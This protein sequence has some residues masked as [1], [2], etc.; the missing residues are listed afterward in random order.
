MAVEFRSFRVTL[1]SGDRYWT[2]IDQSYRPVVE[3][4]DFLLACRLGRDR[5]EGTTQAYATA[6]GLFL[7]WCKDS[8]TDWTESAPHLSRFVF[9]LQ[10]YDPQRR[11]SPGDETPIRG[12]RRVNAILAAVREFIRHAVSVG[13]VPNTILNAL[14][15]VVRDWD[16]PTE[17]RGERD[18]AYRERPRHRLSVP[19][20]PVD[21][22]TGEEILALLR[23]C[24]NSRDRFIVIALGRMGPRRGELTGARREDVH[25]VPDGMMLGCGVKGPHL[26]VVRRMN[27]NGAVAKSRRPRA[28]PADWLVVQAYDQYCM[29]RD[30]CPEAAGCDFL[31]VNLYQRPLGRPMRPQALNELL[32]RLSRRAGLGRVVHPHQLRHSFAN[33]VSESGATLDE[34]KDLLGHAAITSSE[35][36]LH[37]A[38]DRLREAVD[39]VDLPRLPRGDR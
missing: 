26:H 28:I 6:I 36:Y 19:D 12:P 39:R 33:A 18:V 8:G 4:D 3:V 9:W 16:L 5:A 11:R 10:H 37:P 27:P 7:Q 20:E 22:A 38:P 29:A 24:R 30:A 17:V 23:A 32:E 31:L 35:V 14:Y 21:D 13:A 34:I 2:V 1:P 15:D 25:F